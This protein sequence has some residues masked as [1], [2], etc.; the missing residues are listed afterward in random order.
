METTKKVSCYII[1]VIFPV[2]SVSLQGVSD[3]PEKTAVI[4]VLVQASHLWVKYLFFRIWCSVGLCPE[5]VPSR[6]TTGL[7]GI[8][9]GIM[10]AFWKLTKW[11][12]YLSSLIIL[13]IFCPASKKPI[14]FNYSTFWSSLIICSSLTNARDS[15]EFNIHIGKLRMPVT[16]FWIYWLKWGTIVL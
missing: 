1:Y 12:C 11:K 14:A 7:Q 16:C 8:S 5:A 13:F 4:Q 3:W 6:Y 9:E 2:A 10:P 15:L